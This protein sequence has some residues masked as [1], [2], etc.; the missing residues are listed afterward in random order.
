MDLQ[1]LPKNSP[2]LQ[3]EDVYFIPLVW[4]RVQNRNLTFNILTLKLSLVARHDSYDILQINCKH[5]V[6][7][8]FLRSGTAYI[9]PTYTWVTGFKLTTCQVYTANYCLTA[10]GTFSAYQSDNTRCT[11][12]SSVCIGTRLWDLFLKGGGWSSILFASCIYTFSKLVWGLGPMDW[13][14]GGLV[15]FRSY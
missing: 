13:R 6:S 3:W 14:E 10:V 4:G 12:D 15:P 7:R 9:D 1:K 5:F 8:Q 11:R 2:L